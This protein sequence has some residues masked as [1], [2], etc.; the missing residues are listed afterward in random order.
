M[1]PMLMG[2]GSA[3]L[4]IRDRKWN[5]LCATLCE[6]LNFVKVD[7]TACSARVCMDQLPSSG[8]S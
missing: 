7:V 3:T 5:G 6:A 8:M 2:N 4:I 1:T